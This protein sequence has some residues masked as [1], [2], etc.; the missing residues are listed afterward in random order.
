M[1]SGF[2]SLGVKGNPWVSVS[3]EPRHVCLRLSIDASGD[4]EERLTTCKVAKQDHRENARTERTELWVP[5]K[6][7]YQQSP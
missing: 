1:Q 7:F 6:A 3:V 5:A 2:G 4:S